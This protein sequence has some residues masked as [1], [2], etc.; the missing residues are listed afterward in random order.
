MRLP[1]RGRPRCA[2]LPLPPS[3]C[4]W[5][6]RWRASIGTTA[7]RR[8]GWRGALAS[9]ARKEG[10]FGRGRQGNRAA[11]A[12]RTSHQRQGL[13]DACASRGV[14]NKG[15]SVLQ[16]WKA[17]RP[18]GSFDFDV[19]PPLAAA[20]RPP[21][22]ASLSRIAGLRPCSTGNERQNRKNG[23]LKSEKD[24]P[25]GGG[26]VRNREKLQKKL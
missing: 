20:L 10:N 11:T 17:G 16:I 8:R 13:T 2:G 18:T 7:D 21:S 25:S 4:W 12:R 14:P 6:V 1:G 26:R 22:S 24:P 23:S 15:K 19:P 3:C 9:A 5:R